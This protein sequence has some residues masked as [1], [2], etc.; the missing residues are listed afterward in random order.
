MRRRESMPR[1]A[2]QAGDVLGVVRFSAPRAPRVLLAV[3]EVTPVDAAWKERASAAME[4][5]A[6]GDESAFLELYDL[7][8]PRLE[9]FFARR[10]D[11]HAAQDLVQQTF[12]HV[13]S[14]R[15]HFSPGAN[16]VPWAYAI[17]RSLLNDR[18]RRAHK[19]VLA[20][21]ERQAAV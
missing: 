3:S 2:E 17:A 7:L 21:V 6:D 12:L 20:S 10:C 14:A 1:F 13:H 18:Y 4:H 11:K 8:A 16:V 5:Y 15:R 19:E 9:A